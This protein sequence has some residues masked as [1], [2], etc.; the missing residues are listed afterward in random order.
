M[1]ISTNHSQLLSF[2]KLPVR[3]GQ[4]DQ[5]PKIEAAISIFFVSYIKISRCQE[6]IHNNR[7][8]KNH[9]AVSCTIQ[10]IKVCTPVCAPF[11][12]HGAA[13]FV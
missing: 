13:S 2:H 8:T 5:D 7:I 6:T 1:L 9:T 10:S 11:S 12:R 3:H 4:S